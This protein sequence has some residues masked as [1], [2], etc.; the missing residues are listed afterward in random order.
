MPKRYRRTKF[1]NGVFDKDIHPGIDVACPIG[2][3]VLAVEAGTIVAAGTYPESGEHWIMLQI[4]PGTIFFATHLKREG[5]LVPVGRQVA[6]GARIALT[7]NSG[8]STGPHIHFEIRIGPK[9]QDPR[10][11]AAWFRWN[12]LRLRTGG[13]LAHLEE[14][15]PL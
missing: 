2:T 10:S 12:P 13:D 6:R 7:G 8:W 14:I 9:H 15:K 5:I 3:P 4:R 11:S 1:T